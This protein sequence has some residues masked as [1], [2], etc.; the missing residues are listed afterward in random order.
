MKTWYWA[1]P[2]VLMGCLA[3]A[4]CDEG[5]SGLPGSTAGQS[6]QEKAMGQLSPEDRR[7]AEAQRICPV[8]GSALGEMGTPVK[9]MVKGQ[10][11]FLC[12]DG[13][14]KK[15]LDNPDKTLAAVGKLPGQ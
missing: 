7:L 14:T 8:T 4:G 12:C 13:C 11:V 9:V 2:A 10:P 15:A 1:A 5:V 6:D 3:L